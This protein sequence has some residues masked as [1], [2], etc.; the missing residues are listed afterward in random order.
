MH[1]YIYTLLSVH[2]EPLEISLP[3]QFVK[4]ETP[5]SKGISKAWRLNEHPR[6][7]FRNRQTSRVA[8]A[9]NPTWQWSP[10]SKRHP[11]VSQIH[12]TCRCLSPV[13]LHHHHRHVFGVFSGWFLVV[14]RCLFCT[15]LVGWVVWCFS[16]VLSFTQFFGSPLSEW[17]G[18]QQ[19]WNS[20]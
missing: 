6:R 2:L 15:G 3:H 19:L 5:N 1:I 7:L 10:K 8:R 16:F 18:T 20:S 12:G 4:T 17:H 13:V 14:F 11:V 9:R